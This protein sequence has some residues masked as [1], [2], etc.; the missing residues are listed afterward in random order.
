MIGGKE[1]KILIQTRGINIR[2]KLLEAT[3]LDIS[4]LLS[5]FVQ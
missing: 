3:I 4:I 2:K 5:I 1:T